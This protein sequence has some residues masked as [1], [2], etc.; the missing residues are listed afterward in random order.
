MNKKQITLLAAL[1]TAIAL[2]GNCAAPQDSYVAVVQQRMAMIDQMPDGPAKAAAYDKLSQDIDR[3]RQTR[4][5]ELSA[6]SAAQSS[7]PKPTPYVDPFPTPIQVQVVP[8][9]YHY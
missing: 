8:S 1:A 7:E 6:L 3:E 9:P 5:M 2:L 4:A